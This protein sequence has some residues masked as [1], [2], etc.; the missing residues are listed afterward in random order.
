MRKLLTTMWTCTPFKKTLPLSEYLRMYGIVSLYRLE[1]YL[2]FGD[3]DST[4]VTTIEACDGL[5]EPPYP[6]GRMFR[7]PRKAKFEASTL[8]RWLAEAEKE[9]PRLFRPQTFGKSQVIQK[10]IDQKIMRVLDCWTGKIVV[11]DPNTRYLALSYVW[12]KDP[13]IRERSSAAESSRIAKTVDIASEPASIKD[14]AQLVRALGER[15]LWV[16]SIC[17]DQTS[18]IEKGVLIS[19]M[20]AIYRNAYV[21]IIAA[22]NHADAGLDRLREDLSQ[23]ET[24]ITISTKHWSLSFLAARP[25]LEDEL[26]MSVWSTRGCMWHSWSLVARTNTI[27]G[28]RDLPGTSIIYRERHIH[29]Q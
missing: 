8:L 19:H 4:L 23:V 21:A 17:I 12:S 27:Y 13:R 15:Y 20:D 7:L 26:E 28:Y 10:L 18:N 6:S 11:L 5:P 24:P 29:L 2:H 22:G 9:N 14:A 3:E 25:S 16:D 1:I